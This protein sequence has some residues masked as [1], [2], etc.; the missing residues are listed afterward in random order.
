MMVKKIVVVGGVA[1]GASAAA[2]CRRLDE[3][4]EITIFEKGPDVAFSNCSLPYHLSQ[5]IDV[6]DDII[7]MRPIDLEMQY[8]IAVKVN[9]EVTAIDPATKSVT[10]HNLEADTTETVAYDELVLAPGAVPIRPDK[11]AGIHNDNVFTIRNVEDVKHILGYLLDRDITDVTVIGGGFVGVEAAENLSNGGF[12]VNL[13]EAHDHVLKTLDDDMAQIVQKTMLDYEINLIVNDRVTAITD[14]NVTLA[15]GCQLKSQAVIAAIGVAPETD[16]ATQAG[17]ATGETGAIKVDQHFQTNIPHIHAVGD[18]IEVF[19]WQTGKPQRLNLAF[20]AQ[21]EARQAADHIYGRQ[22]RNHGVIGSQCIPVFELNVA[23]TGMNEATCQANHIDYR[24]TTVIPL[25]KVSLMP[26]AKSLFLKLVFAYPTGEILGAQAIGESAVDKQIDVIATMIAN[27][28]YV[29]DLETLELCYQPKMSTAKNAV[30]MA[31]MVAT[32]LLND[33]YR[34]VPVSAVRGLVE[35]GAMIVDV[36][37]KDEYRDGHLT[38]S[39]NIPM[40]EFR[41]R[42]DEI[43]K[44]RPVYFHCL[45]SQR[46]YNVVRALINLGY[47]NVYNIVGSYKGISYYEYYRDQVEHRKPIV[48]TY[49]FDIVPDLFLERSPITFNP[50]RMTQLR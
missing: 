27:H 35:S 46:S 20:P 28:N 47:T 26:G 6:A 34:Q 41:D 50:D 45:T 2:R 42:L 24:T 22:V 25:D 3:S 10:V 8:S 44:D 14:K 4:A 9:H 49:W 11:I 31:G 40:S 48:T 32:N 13:V 33:E 29:E 19:N 12:Q 17:I 39:V 37:E 7:V 36:R 16:L 5:M 21:I 43:P 30:N 15:S 1:G 18:A 23:S 38:T